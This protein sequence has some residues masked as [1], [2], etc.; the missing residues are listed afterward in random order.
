G[1]LYDRRQ[2]ADH[3]GTRDK[4]CPEP[5]EGMTITELVSGTVGGKPIVVVATYNPDT[6]H[7]AG[8]VA[9]TVEVAEHG[10][11]LHEAWRVPA[12]GSAEALA[13]FRAPPTRPI[14]SDVG[15]EP[16]VWVADNAKNGR[17]LAIRLRDGHILANMRTAGWPMGN[18]KPVIFNHV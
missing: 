5:N 10:P 14:I 4:P 8:V 13:W 12:A 16:V 11:K 3:C 7:A 9:Y 6:V 18:A 15:G 17:I 1:I 2:V